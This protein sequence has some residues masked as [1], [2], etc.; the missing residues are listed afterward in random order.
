MKL[1]SI[2]DSGMG[3]KALCM[4]IGFAGKC[5]Y[6]IKISYIGSVGCLMKEKNTELR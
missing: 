2:I 4:M 3:W 5:G 6:P 1:F